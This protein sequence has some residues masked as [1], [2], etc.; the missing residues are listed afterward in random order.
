MFGQFRNKT[1]EKRLDNFAWT[2]KR[3]IKQ[4]LKKWC[5]NGHCGYS[6]NFF[7]NNDLTFF[8]STGKKGKETF[9]HVY[10]IHDTYYTFGSHVCLEYMY[11]VYIF[12]YLCTLFLFLHVSISLCLE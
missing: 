9:T 5:P 2:P 1:L 7:A 8:C 12:T 6:Q 4:K 11:S 3:L 10:I